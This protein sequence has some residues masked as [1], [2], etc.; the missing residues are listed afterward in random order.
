MAIPD[1][2]LPSPLRG[3]P[4]I[5]A[6]DQTMRE[7]LSTIDPG[8]VL[9]HLTEQLPES[10][11]DVLIEQWGLL[12]P[13]FAIANATEAVKRKLLREAALLNSRRGTIWA[14]RYIFDVA[15]LP[16][17]EVVEAPELNEKRLLD[18]TW[19]LN[20]AW[21]LG[22][23]WLW[24]QYAVKLLDISGVTISPEFLQILDALLKAYAPARCAHIGYTT[25]GSFAE[26]LTIG[27]VLAI[28]VF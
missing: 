3:I 10:A 24:A 15:G 27:D 8:T 20:G 9:V 22:Y 17:I 19:I 16:S 2:I 6:F 23:E 21:M 18:G 26:E 1:N 25:V 12:S 28:N 5:A 4:H 11:L 13:G 7:L 14:I